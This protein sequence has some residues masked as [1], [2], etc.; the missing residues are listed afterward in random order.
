MRSLHLPEREASIR[1]HDLPGSSPA[2]VFLHGLGAASSSDLAGVA[3]RAPFAGRRRLLVDLL[4]FGFS[5][6]PPGCAYTLD[7]HARSVAAVLDAA[8]AGNCWVIGHSMGGTV[9]IV[10]AGLRPDLVSA[11][12][13]AEGN[14]DP[15]VGSVSVE[16]AGWA[17]D[18]YL[19]RG[20]QALLRQV[21]EAARPEDP[22]MEAY[23]G[24]FRLA[25]PLAVHRSAVG[26]LAPIHPTA[27]ERLYR[28]SG[29][30]AYV[31][32]ERSLPDPDQEHLPANGVE[33]IVIPGAG[34]SMTVEAPDDLARLVGG[35][36]ERAAP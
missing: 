1:F 14:L 20:H 35:Y 34:H 21:S 11:L 24:A 32:G 31:F 16:I 25:D 30:K 28:F 27:R 15:G 29:P 33:V 8:R 9:A 19:A 12:V 10:L 13:V 26:L 23:L 36:L 22:G 4:G 18:E 2:V 3:A 7:D 6:R 17:E 5:D